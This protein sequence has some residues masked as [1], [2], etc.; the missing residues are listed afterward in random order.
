MAAPLRPLVLLLLPQRLEQFALRE[1]AERLLEAEDVVAVDPPRIAYGALAHLPIAVAQAMA[2]RVARRLVKVLRR[3]GDRP[4]V[5]VL[6]DPVQALHGRALLHLVP[7]C[8][9]WYGRPD[10]DIA[11]PGAG[12]HYRERLVQLDE[13]AARL[14]ARTFPLDELGTLEAAPAGGRPQAGTGTAGS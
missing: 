11:H 13:A 3:N 7:E 9:L 5:V 14:A 1:Q 8:E 6:L 2:G 12:P 10:L 4:R